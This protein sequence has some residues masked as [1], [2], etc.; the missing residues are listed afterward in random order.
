MQGPHGYGGY[1]YG[2]DAGA[3]GSAG[4]GG[5][6][7]YNSGAYGYDAVGAYGAPGDGYYSNGY[8][9]PAPAYY[10]DPI[11]AGRRAHDV[12]APLNGLQLQA[13]EACPRNYV[14]FDQTRATSRVMFHPSLPHN[15]ASGSSSQAC[16]DGGDAGGKE[17]EDAAEIDALLSSEDSDDEVVSTGRAPGGG[18][19]GSPDS[20]YSCSRGGRARKKERVSRMMRAL[21]GIVPGGDRMDT[22]AVLDGAVRYLK[23]LKVEAKKLGVRGGSDS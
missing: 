18:D 3:Y 7:G 16:H 20:A 9:P 1:G 19:E 2:Y 17:D 6:Y 21:R 5:G 4:G 23:E 10:E 12:P 15:L 11:A 14:I 13:S 22:P 8:P